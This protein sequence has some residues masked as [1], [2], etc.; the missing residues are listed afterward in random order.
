MRECAPIMALIRF[1]P[2]RSEQIRKIG[3]GLV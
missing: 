2:D 1:D 3:R